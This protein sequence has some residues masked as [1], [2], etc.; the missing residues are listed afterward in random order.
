MFQTGSNAWKTY[1]A[2]PPRDGVETK[3][4]YLHANGELDWQKPAGG[5]D[6]FVSYVSD[7]AKPVPY[8]KRPIQGF[9]QG[10][11]DSKDPRF[12]RA[13][14]LWKVED[15]RFVAD[16]PD[17]ISFVTP[18]LEAEVEVTGKIVAKLF[19]STTGTDADW[20]VKLIDVYPESYP[21][22][23]EMG[24]YQLMVADD[25]TRGKFHKSMK[26]PVPLEPGAVNE[27][28]IDLRTRN[29]LFRKGHRIMVQIQ[30]SWFPLIDRNP[31]SFVDIP[32]ATA[33]NFQKAEQR[34]YCSEQH[35]SHIDLML[36]K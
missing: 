23:P 4:L 29:H 10:L 27:F 25:V 21:E 15:Q 17:V 12:D 31:Q 26:E 11:K 34:I 5:N 19:A 32:T 6:Q 3:P 28:T 1:D 24:G 22:R 36:A 8:S 20:V 2:W 30:S 14:R 13:G 16:R 7:P 33:E 18:P 35:P 9:W